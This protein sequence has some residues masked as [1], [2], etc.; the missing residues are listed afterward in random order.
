MKALRHIRCSRWHR[1]QRMAM[2]TFSRPHPLAI[3]LIAGVLFLLLCLAPI[4]HAQLGP[5]TID[6]ELLKAR[7]ERALTIA[8]RDFRQLM[9]PAQAGVQL[10]SV[11][12]E[13]TS[14]AWQRITIDLSQKALTYDPSGSVEALLDRILS[15]TAALTANAGS[16]DYRFLVDGLPLERF[17]PQAPARFTARR[18]F[19]EGG[20]AVVSAG[21]GWYWNETYGAW[22]LQRDYYRGIVEDVVNWDIANYLRAELG[23]NGMGAQLVRYPDRD[24]R[25]G[26]SGHPQWQESAKYFIRGLGAP[27]EVWDIGVDDYARDINARPIYSNWID[28][29]VIISI[30][31]NGGGGTGT[32]TWYDAANGFEEESQRLAQAVNDRIVTLIRE[33]YNR[34]WPDRGLRACNGCK[35]ENRLAARPAIIVEG[36]FMD[37]PSPD[38]DALHDETFKRLVAQGIREGLQH[39]AA[40]RQ[41]SGQAPRPSAGQAPRPSA[42]QATLP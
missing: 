28:A 6:A 20:S 2:K 10:L 4:T 32:E 41:S 21:H 7:I 13:R 19:A 1:S 42:G 31:N 25:I 5:P 17:L 39:W 34:D 9:A 40:P 14:A 8:P 11:R 22:L 26:A 38:N 15:D 37:T 30:H 36:A 23:A 18:S 29:A 27:T 16:V 3:A 33:R 24:G 12:V 35:G